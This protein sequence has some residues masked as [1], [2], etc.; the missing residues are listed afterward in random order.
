MLIFLHL[1]LG[2]KSKYCKVQTFSSSLKRSSLINII[3]KVLTASRERLKMASNFKK[4]FNQ[5]FLPSFENAIGLP[6]KLWP[7]GCRSRNRGLSRSRGRSDGLISKKSR[8]SF[9]FHH[10]RRFIH[11]HT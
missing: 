5:I 8:K 11:C 10:S 1:Q 2:V 3:G 6:L 7:V 9:S 4:T